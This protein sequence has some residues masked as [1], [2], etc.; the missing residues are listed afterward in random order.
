[1]NERWFHCILTTYGAWLPGDPRG[2]RTRHHREHIEGDYKSPPPAGQYDARHARSRLLQKHPTVTLTPH[3]RS[4]LGKA[5]VHHLQNRNIQLL[6][7]ALG[8]QH[9]HLQLKSERQAIVDTLGRL[10]RALCHQRCSS[11]N[12][13]PLWAVGR[14]IVPIKS[15]DHQEAVF[16]YILAHKEQSAW[17]WSYRDPLP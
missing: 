14:K 17:T 12:N 16:H 13:A 15:R 11:G 3:E 9:L 6:S 4:D 2:F 7:M 10:K 1:M 5:A 8:G